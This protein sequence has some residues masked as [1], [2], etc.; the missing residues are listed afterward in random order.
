[1]VKKVGNYQLESRIGE[2]NYGTVYLGT[3]IQTGEPFA[4]KAVAMRSLNNKLLKQMEAEIK[5]LKASE[6]PNIIKLQ[7][8]LKTTNNVYLVM[9]YCKGGDLEH[10]C[11][12]HGKVPEP[13]AKKWLSELVEAFIFLQENQIMHR[14]LKLANILLTSDSE[15]EASIKVADFGFARFLN[16]SSLAQTQ[17]G[18][19]LFMAPEIFNSEHYSFKADV[20]SLGVLSYE[21]LLGMPA[22][23]CRTLAQLRRLQ[24]DGVTFPSNTDLSQEAQ[25]FV[26]AMLTYDHNQRPSFQE[27]RSHPFLASLYE[28]EPDSIAMSPE[29]QMEDPEP[30]EDLNE[31]D[32]EI[33]GEESDHEC[34]DCNIEEPSVSGQV[35]SGLAKGII[36]LE[37]E[38]NQLTELMK[39]SLTN[40]SESS[41]LVAFAISE[42]LY[43][44]FQ[45]CFESAENLARNNGLTRSKDVLFAELYDNIQVQMIETSSEREKLK[46]KL[47]RGYSREKSAEALCQVC[48]DLKA[49]NPKRA[50]NLISIALNLDPEN[51]EVQKLY[52]EVSEL[53]KKLTHK[54]NKA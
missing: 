54:G 37:Y 13:T 34:N 39:F 16:G 41:P 49:T 2:G 36:E 29:V 20:W 33:I 53:F 48:Q 43:T 18:T 24:E 28:E 8:V 19:P 23:L 6:H 50:N 26:Q 12:I 47:P 52:E 32:Y 5:V 42:F 44:S 30:Q 51:F 22:F 27:L 21:I 17:L 45:N 35:Q 7:E 25:S 1:M 3:H 10:Y 46:E 15:N 31:S 4:I 11:K 40:Y 9:E 14:D 38:V